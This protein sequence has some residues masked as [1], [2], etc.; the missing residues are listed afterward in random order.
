MNVTV[1]DEAVQIDEGT[2]VAVGHGEAAVDGL[3]DKHDL[4]AGLVD[5]LV[6]DQRLV[7]CLVDIA[8][9]PLDVAGSPQAGN[10]ARRLADAIAIGSVTDLE[11]LAQ[12]LG[13]EVIDEAGWAAIVAGAN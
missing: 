9:F 4:G 12:E 1:N 10:V 13:I 5:L 11:A 2:T 8:D 6:G 7:A 3:V